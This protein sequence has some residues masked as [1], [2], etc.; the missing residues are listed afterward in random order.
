MRNPFEFWQKKYA[1]ALTLAL[2]LSAATTFTLL[3]AFVLPKSYTSG[4]DDATTIVQSNPT[5]QSGSLSQTSNSTDVARNGSATSGNQN[6]SIISE[7]SYQDDN[8]S[9]RIETVKENG[10]VYYVADVQLSDASYLKTAFANNTFGKNIT[11]TTSAMAEENNAIFAV[12]GDYYGFRDTGLIIR[13]GVL[14]RDTPRSSP[15]NQTLTVDSAGNLA[16]VTEDEVSGMELLKAGILQSFS[17]GPILVADGKTVNQATKTTS[18]S[19][20]PRTAIGQI[21]PLHYIFVVAD[22]RSSESS[23]MTLSQLAQVFVDMGCTI[24]YNLDGGGSSS[25]WLNGK[26]INNPTNGRKSG[27]R[28]ISDIIYIGEGGV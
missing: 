15:D 12:N 14:Y 4:A 27:E 25:L 6:E 20:N 13:N 2:I 23:G 8:L 3:D 7:N 11:Q 26:L 16:V 9:I 21:A 18:Q 28:S 24:A 17:F 1:W 5:A 10:F 19:A 22:G